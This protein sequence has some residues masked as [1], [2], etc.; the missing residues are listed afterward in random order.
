MCKAS[1]ESVLEN[2]SDAIF[3]PIFWFV[4][5]GIPAVLIYRLSNTLDAMWGYKT[6]RYLY[7]GRF[8]ARMDDILNWLPSRLVGISYAVL[9]NTQHA[10]RC[11]Q[12]QAHLL[13]SPSGGVVMS[14]GAGALN[15]C[16]GGDTSYHGTLKSKPVFGCGLPPTH[17]D[18]HR[19]VGLVS[20]TLLLWCSVL[21]AC[22]ILLVFVY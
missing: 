5:G 11:W 17:Q 8:S 4:V 1:V 20:K 2:G 16:L 13:E 7:F 21:V 15:V 14:T 12:E 6:A 19:S 10:Y 22:A 3:A 9:G 18:L